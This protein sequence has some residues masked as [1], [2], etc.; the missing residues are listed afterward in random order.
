MSCVIGWSGP[1]KQSLFACQCSVK[2]RCLSIGMGQIDE[3]EMSSAMMCSFIFP[4]GC[5]GCGECTVAVV[6]VHG[7]HLSS[8]QPI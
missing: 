5:F 6:L 8:N 1:G 4:G 3:K 2:T 7:Y